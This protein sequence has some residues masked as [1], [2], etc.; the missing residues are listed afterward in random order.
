MINVYFDI[1]M[2]LI[3]RTSDH[4]LDCLLLTSLSASSRLRALRLAS[5]VPATHG[6]QEYPLDSL[7]DYTIPLSYIR[8][9]AMPAFISISYSGHLW[10]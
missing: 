3:S 9:S 4:R 6:D 7:K 2:V 1:S 10:F 5:F 8:T